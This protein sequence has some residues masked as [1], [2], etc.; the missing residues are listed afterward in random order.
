ML[1][2]LSN[3]IPVKL[4]GVTKRF[5]SHTAVSA[6]DLEVPRG[7]IYGLLGPNGS[8]KTTTLRIIMGIL[9]PDE[10]E[11]ELMGGAPG[12]KQN[13]RV[14]YLPEERGVYRKMKVRDLLVFLGEIRGLARGEALRRTMEWLDRLDLTDWADKRTQDLSKG[15][16]QKVQFIGTVLHEPDILILDEPFSGLDPINQEV[17]EGIVREF[18]ARGT[19]ILFSTHLMDH[20][21]RLCERV[22]LISKAEKVLDSDLKELKRKERKGLV[23][24]EF[25]GSD[26]WLRGPEVKEIRAVGDAVHLVLKE[27]ADHQEILR[28]GVAAGVRIDLF[29]LVE[30]RLHEIFVRHAGDP[31]N[32]DDPVAGGELA[33]SLGGSMAGEGG[34]R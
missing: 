16:Q 26:S 2:S 8:G 28:R 21:E 12:V 19:T 11:V 34:I 27:G 15:M 13:R 24:V 4:T 5:G 30:P 7:S 29:D 1:N 6:L 32:G 22:C 10:G 33:R 23:A 20:A 17:L 25:E 18:Q 3:G 31:D 14:G 9:L